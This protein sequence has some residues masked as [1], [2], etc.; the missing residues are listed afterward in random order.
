MQENCRDFLLEINVEELPAGYIEPALQQLKQDFSREFVAREIEG[1]TLISFG[2][3]NLLGCYIKDVPLAQKGSFKEVIGPPKRIA[4]DD[5]GNPTRQAIGFAKNQGVELEDLKIKQTSK[6]EYVTIE[7]KEEVRDIKDIL[8][9]ITPRI[10]KGIDFPKTMKWDNSNLRFARPIESV[11]ALFGNESIP[12]QVG[13]V[14]QKKIKSIPPAKYLKA[15]KK[16]CLIDSRGRKKKIKSLILS[17]AKRLKADQSVDENLLD[18]VTFMVNFPNVFVGE[19]NREFLALPEDVL[20]ASMSKYQRLFPVTRQNRLVNNFI[21][22]IEGS[23]RNIRRVRRNYEN[24]LEARLKDSLFFFDEDTKKP[25]SQNIF[26]LKELIFQKNLGNMFEKIQRL[27]EICSFVCDKLGVDGSLKMDIKRA[28][29]LSKADLLS[30]MVGEFPSLQGIMG[31]EYALKSGEKKEVAIAIREHYLPQGTDDSLPRSK[32][33]AILAISEKMDNLVGF[34]GMDVERISG[35]FD[36]FGIR[37]NALGLIKIIK[38][39]TF[40]FKIDEL[41]QKSIELYGDKLNVTPSQFKKRI[42]DYIKE[43]IEFL[44]GDARPIELKKAVLETSC[45]DIADIFKKIKVL[46]SISDKTYFLQAAKVVERTSNILKGAQGERIGG[47]NKGL[48]REDLEQKVWKAYL[49]KKDA[50]E[51]FINNEKYEEATREYGQVFFKVL[52]DFFD[53]VLVN[54]EDKALRLNRLAIMKAINRLYAEH[55]ADLAVL[56]QIVVNKNKF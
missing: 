44:M 35:S 54:V 53:K 19:F 56:P 25:L 22:V 41:I 50:I 49:D 47:V 37:R 13:N 5:K 8:Q 43:R 33:G 18:E 30:H 4:F 16:S 6:G 39:Q 21:A 15:L 51:C 31:G 48:F 10:I 26:Q 45:L 42:I 28:A 7:K 12:I 46:A 34:S 9:E 24:I 11:L 36:P 55:V 14:L 3:K 2:T 23:G 27:Q 38:D 40:R 1:I 17:A 29:E 20:R 52:H 32:A